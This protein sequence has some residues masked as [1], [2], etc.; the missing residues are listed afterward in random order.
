MFCA[1]CGSNVNDDVTFCPNCGKSPKTV[2]ASDSATLPAGAS[3]AS[4][5][6]QNFN[7]SVGYIKPKHNFPLLNL[8]AKLFSIFFE[9]SLW[10]LLILGVIIGGFVGGYT[11]GSLAAIGGVLVGGIISF[12]IM[13]VS[14]GLVSI[15]VRINDNIEELIQKIK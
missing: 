14:G 2:A 11:G 3:Q 5:Y 10:I 4:V 13:V 8:T 7:S 9:I 12:I 15:F 1:N 6:V